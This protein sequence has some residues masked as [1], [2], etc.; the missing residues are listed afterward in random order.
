MADSEMADDAGSAVEPAEPV[1]K[2]AM[3]AK[4][5]TRKPA[6]MTYAQMANKL[7]S[8]DV[9]AI[10]EAF[11][12]LAEIAPP[13]KPN[14]PTSAAPDDGEDTATATPADAKKGGEDK[15]DT[16]MAAEAP[17]LI[18]GLGVSDAR[19]DA[20]F[21]AWDLIRSVASSHRAVFPIVS[22]VLTTTA[23]PTPSRRH[24]LVCDLVLLVGFRVLRAAYDAAVGSWLGVG[25]SRA[26]C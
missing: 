26:T 22:G 1:A 20:F 15:Q 14:T 2:R 21:T 23:T 3:V 18:V 10:V 16:V 11:A 9:N 12:A 19:A 17:A 7:A 8:G 13:P 25:G 5:S 4:I 6:A 24:V